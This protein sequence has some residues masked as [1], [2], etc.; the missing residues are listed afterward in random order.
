MAVEIASYYMLSRFEMEG[1]KALQNVLPVV[2]WIT[3]QRNSDGGFISTQVNSNFTCTSQHYLL[4]YIDFYCSD[5]LH[6]QFQKTHEFESSSRKVFS[7]ISVFVVRLS[8]VVRNKIMLQV[9][10]FS[11]SI[12]PP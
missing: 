10:G 8:N 12:I 5:Y 4:L 6:E 2:R 7:S 3:H 11:L 9:I 1:D